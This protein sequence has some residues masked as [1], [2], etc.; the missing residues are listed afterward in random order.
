VSRVAL[1][2]GG[3][4]GIG[5]AICVALQAAG[6]SVAATFCHDDAKAAHFRA[7]HDVPVFKWAVG[8]F[9]ACGAGVGQVEAAVGPIEVLVN[10]VGITRD[11]ALHKMNLAQRF[12]RCRIY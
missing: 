5:A 6:Y 7:A 8:D 11:A 1:V 9:A 3:T 12:G 2:T 10:N 4:D